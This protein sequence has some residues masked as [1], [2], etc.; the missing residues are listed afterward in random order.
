MRFETLSDWLAWQ[1]RLHPQAI[2]LGLERVRQVASRLK[3]L[4]WGIPIVTVAGTNGKGSCVAYLNAIYSAAGYCAGVY[5][6]PHLIRYNERIRIRN[7]LA[8]DQEICAAFEQVEQARGDV[9]LTYFEFGT[10]AALCLFRQND[11][12]LLILEVGLGGR[13]DAVNIL[14]ADLALI[15]S[16]SADH[17]AWLGKDLDGIAR[18]KA[19]V[20]RPGKPAV[21]VDP[22]PPLGLLDYAQEYGIA[23][24][25][26][27]REF[28]RWVQDEQVLV[29]E[30]C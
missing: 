19:A 27:G 2:E 11:C 13:L 12:D 24:D 26:A 23:I 28:S 22:A 30:K 7:Q 8:A 9:S 1:E 5:T 20:M 10:L 18:E 3:L 4:Q 16:I 25:L 17:E 6:S 15:T 21:S 14:D 29:L